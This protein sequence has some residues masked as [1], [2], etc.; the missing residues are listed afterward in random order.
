MAAAETAGA[1][2][3]TRVKFV[4]FLSDDQ[5]RVLFY[6]SG[7]RRTGYVVD[8]PARERVLRDAVARYEGWDRGLAPFLAVP[9]FAVFLWLVR[10]HPL[11]G[12]G[13]VATFI[14]VGQLGQDFI[15]GIVLSRHVE[16]LQ[17][18]A[19]QRPPWLLPAVFGG[20]SLAGWLIFELYSWRL[21]SLPRGDAISVF[22]VDISWAIIC[23]LL[24]GL[25]AFGLS[26][27]P[28]SR[29][30]SPRALL[31]LLGCVVIA[32]AG[33]LVILLAFIAARP[34]VT[35]TPGILFCGWDVAW[36]E[37]SDISLKTEQ[38]TRLSPGAWAV[39]SLEPGSSAVSRVRREGFHEPLSC[40]ISGL[41]AS[42]DVVYQSIRDAWVARRQA[43]K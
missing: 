26:R 7:L 35:V 23:A 15:S 10:S 30:K 8:T 34:I 22:Y 31:A 9:P 42:Y 3:K 19:A 29:L 4:R 36:L 17:R 2:K 43:A 14:L 1:E 40:K 12:F 5:G 32:A 41:N 6:P 24:G 16:G 38:S 20:P 28:S 25:V 39:V 11:L 37:V 21:A 27:L 13:F 33:L 18:V